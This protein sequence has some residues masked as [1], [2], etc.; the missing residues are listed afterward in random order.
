MN[1]SDTK[2]LELL[3]KKYRNIKEVTTEIINLQAILN[4][5]KGTELF[6]SDLH[7]EYEAFL[8]ILNNGS[9]IIKSKIESLYGNTIT[10]C[11][12][13]SLATL[14]YYPEEKLELIKK[15]TENMN[16]WYRIILYRLIEV[17]RSVSSKYT[18]S[19]VRKAMP[20]GFDYII[21]ELLHSQG[22]DYNKDR[23]YSQIIDSII[24][25]GRADAFIIAMSALIKRMA[26]DHL[27]IIGDIYDRGPGGPIIMD[28]LMEFHSL[29]IQWGNHDI[30][31][32]GAQCGNLACIANVVRICSRYDNLATLEEG[33]GINIRPLSLFAIETYKNDPCNAFLP[34]NSE[35]NRYTNTDKVVLS[36]I[37]KAMAVIQFKVEGQLIKKHPEYKMEDR[38]LLDKMN[39]KKGYVYVGKKAYKLNDT[40]FPTID[41]DDPYKLTDKEQEIMDR[42]Q[43]SFVNSEKLYK[44]ISFLYSKGH[45]YQIYNN[46]ILYHGCIPLDKNGELEELEI[47]GKK[48]K[49]KAL[50]DHLENI[51]YKAFAVKEVSE[52]VEDARDLLWYLWCGPKSPLFGKDKAATF[53][54]YFIDDKETH[55]ENKNYYYD[56][57]N[58]EKVCT[59]ILR[60]FGVDI[61]QGHI[62]NG[63]IPVKAK[64][65]ETPVR[66]GGKLIVIDGGFAKAYQKTTGLAGYTLT[67]NSHGLVLASNEPF[68]SKNKAITEGK[69][70]ISQEILKENVANRKTV[71]DTD[72]GDKLQGEIDDLKRL[73]FAYSNGNLKE[74]R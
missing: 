55:K 26:I 25:L 42:L 19:K 32:M 41:K 44:H 5:P 35:I 72:I 49:G 69:D 8:H 63:H 38:L 54:R 64:D 15:E 36:K 68:E 51:A 66:A 40:N 6:M 73:L 45:M 27:H 16:D 46:N 17:T 18:R 53:E 50:L 22:E 11:E 14:I 12:R 52:E 67:Y 58:D 61:E 37:Q 71:R 2:F 65:G 47:M 4:L 20:E 9:G 56:Y 30:V 62:I 1:N 31:W 74:E 48:A 34:R 23:Y 13:K 29:D 7:G 43:R 21:D 28:K 10:E 70:I 24:E 3:S 39:L 59:K 57:Q 60:D 33:Y